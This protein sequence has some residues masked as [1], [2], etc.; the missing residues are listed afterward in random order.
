MGLIFARG[1]Q[2]SQHA[3]QKSA[4]ETE[5]RE[6]SMAEQ[7]RQNVA[8]GCFADGPTR[9]FL[10]IGL[11]GRVLILFHC[12]FQNGTYDPTVGVGM[13]GLILEITFLGT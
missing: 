9:H 7:R 8:K 11:A 4:Q 3:N 12:G 10:K 13:K 6:L 1:E 5:A 2:G